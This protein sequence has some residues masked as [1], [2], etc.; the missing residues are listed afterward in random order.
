MKFA[1]VAENVKRVSDDPLLAYGL[2]L[3]REIWIFG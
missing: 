2:P 1:E 3:E